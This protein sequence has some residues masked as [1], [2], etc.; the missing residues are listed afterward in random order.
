METQNS[1]DRTHVL[2]FQ[3]KIKDAYICDLGPIY[4]TVELFASFF[5]TYKGG[6]VTYLAWILTNA[7]IGV[8]D[9]ATAVSSHHVY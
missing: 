1:E 4:T 6:A 3:I 8:C 9:I 2:T 5:E 7:C